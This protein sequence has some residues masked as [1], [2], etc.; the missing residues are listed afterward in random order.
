M[1]LVRKPTGPAASADPDAADVL[2]A[3]SSANADVRWAAARAA[4]GVPGGSEALAAALRVET[5]PQVRE[6][7]FTSLAR[8]G[9][10][11]STG[12]LIGLLRSDQSALRAGALDALRTLGVEVR[13]ILPQLLMDTDADIRILSCELTRALP[14]EE[15]SA[16]LCALLVEEPDVNVCAAAVDILA[17]VGSPAACAALSRCAARFPHSAFLRFAVQIANNRINS[18]SAPPRD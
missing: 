6:A 2:R 5:E 4:A 18:A 13:T 15:A 7:L 14:T 8:I 10:T 17:E 3:L 9:T 12:E 11:H 1:P 16:A